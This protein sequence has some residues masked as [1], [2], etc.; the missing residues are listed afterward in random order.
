MQ[1][2]KLPVGKIRLDERNPR[3]AHTIETLQGTVS[4]DFIELSLGQ[5]APED[6]ERGGSTTYIPG[7]HPKLLHLWPGQIP[8]PGG[9]RTRDDYA[10]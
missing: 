6:E 10:L 1:V 9:G 7:G 4:Q 5:S 3:I 2:Q 8:P